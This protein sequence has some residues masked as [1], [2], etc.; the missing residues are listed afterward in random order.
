MLESRRLLSGSFHPFFFPG[1]GGGGGHFGNGNAIQ[2]DQAPPAAQTALDGLATGDALTPPDPATSTQTVFLGN[3]NGVETYTIYLGT[4]APLTKLTVDING[5]VPVA[6]TIT[7]E[8]FAA[9][10]TN[11]PASAAEITAIAAGVNLTPPTATTN[12]QV[13]TPTAPAGPTF[14]VSLPSAIATGWHHHSTNISVD[15][16]GNPVGDQTLPF[17]VLPTAIQTG[18][19]G[20][21][22]VGATPY[23]ATSTQP[24]FVDSQNGGTTYSVVFTGVGT[25]TKVT[26]AIVDGNP[27]TPPGSTQ[28]TF[29]AV[30]TM[31]AA[32]AA[33]LQTLATADGITTPIASTQAVTQ[34]NEGNGV[35]VLYTVRLAG[36]P[37][38]TPWGGTYTPYTTITVDQAGNPTVLPRGGDDWGFGF[39]DNFGGEGGFGEFSS[40]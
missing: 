8:T 5:N 11:N 22:P 25:Q 27:V 34:Y 33:E 9:L 20:L 7:T 15:D 32:A 29:G 28:T 23:A 19:N 13:S 40:D 14:T 36:T 37:V 18:L 26:F 21:A 31:A 39:C 12:V 10:T 4:T 30:Q 38:T 16:L 3:S 35:T 24:V 1:G 6:P 2:F 17:S